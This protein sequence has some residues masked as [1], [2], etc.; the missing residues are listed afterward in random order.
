MNSASMIIYYFHINFSREL[1]RLI[2]PVAIAV[3][4]LSFVG[5]AFATTPTNAD[6]VITCGASY[7]PCSMVSVPMGGVQTISFCMSN[8]AVG[9]I[10]NSNS[11]LGTSGLEVKSPG[12][13]SF[14]DPTGAVT[15]WTYTPAAFVVIPA[16][17]SGHYTVSFGAGTPGWTRLSGPNVAQ[18]AEQGPYTVDLNYKQGTS[19]LALTAFF[20]ASVLVTSVYPV[21]VLGVVT[22][23]LA[24]GA[25]VFFKKRPLHAHKL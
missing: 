22:P 20:D 21:G 17:G 16:C 3:L 7:K 1:N 10:W 15:A 8:G 2:V 25:F 9:V 23:L 12:G 6:V 18:S 13:K 19:L 5:P 4:L 11:G 24:L 14:V